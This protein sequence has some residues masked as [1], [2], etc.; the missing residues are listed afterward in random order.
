MSTAHLYR[1]TTTACACALLFACQPVQQIRERQPAFTTGTESSPASQPETLDP[2]SIGPNYGTKI[3][4]LAK[5]PVSFSTGQ[6]PVL[7]FKQELS[8]TDLLPSTE[9]AYEC[10]AQFPEGYIADLRRQFEGTTQI[11]YTIEYI[12][13]PY[14]K[15]VAYVTL[16]PNRMHY[17]TMEEFN[18]DFFRCGVGGPFPYLLNK[19]WLVFSTSCGGASEG[20]GVIKEVVEPSIKLR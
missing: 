6:L 10:N 12:E 7:I 14:R 8:A 15:S 18:K 16:L 9:Y 2:V 1:F 3:K 5:E 17:A 11:I 4:T 20:C 13:K 19:D